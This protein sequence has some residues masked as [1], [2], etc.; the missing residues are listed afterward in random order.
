MVEHIPI[1]P[2]FL[3]QFFDRGWLPSGQ[4]LLLPID[5]VTKQIATA[6]P[7]ERWMDGWMS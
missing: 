1:L 5:G 6:E 4:L 3:S 2:H 7:M